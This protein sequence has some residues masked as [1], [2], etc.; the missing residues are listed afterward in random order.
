MAAR[1]LTSTAEVREVLE[2]ARTVAVLGF[3]PDPAK[4][5][6]YVPEYL[7]GAGYR[8]IP[9][10]PALAGRGE[11]FFGEPARASLAEIGEP[12]DVVDVF[13]RPDKLPEHTEDILA[14][15]PRPKLVWLQ[16]GIRNDEFAAG[17]LEAGIEVIQDRCMLADHR[18]FG[19]PVR[20]G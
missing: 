16:L 5:A 2:T 12:V 17:L 6:H 13:R 11:S 7:A 15:N 3:N 4:P 14:M 8:I 20:T 9:V 10:N 19:V 1:E 18:R